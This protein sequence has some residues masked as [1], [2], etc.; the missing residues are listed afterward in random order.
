MNKCIICNNPNLNISK[1]KHIILKD[2]LK[3]VC[4]RCKHFSYE[5]NISD[6]EF[7][8]S[9]VANSENKFINKD[10]INILH[11]SYWLNLSRFQM[12]KNY[13]HAYS[14]T[15]NVLEIGPG[16]PGLSYFWSNSKFNYKM[17][18]AEPD[19]LKQKLFK[20][21]F[22]KLSF[23]DIDKINSEIYLEK[24][25]NYFD[26]IILN[27]VFYY[28]KNPDNTISHLKK[29]SRKHGVIFVDIL[30]PKY[31]DEDYEKKIDMRHVF[32]KNSLKT[33]FNNHNFTTL[34]LDYFDTDQKNILNQNSKE[35]SFFDKI[36]Y[37]FLR[38]VR[39]D[40]MVNLTI[41]DTSSNFSNKDGMYLRGIFEND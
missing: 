35:I 17:F 26:I 34:F 19:S 31:V 3:V 18:I 1:F 41:N 11:K 6:K 38:L 15:I 40:L 16:F 25:N 32:N 5:S 24:F 14:K 4:E 20:K 28:F 33:L 30:N 22:S 13:V 27:N 23:F 21:S 9:Y 36:L 10:Q 37:K 39:A 29:I 12:I 2:C 8:T 7:I